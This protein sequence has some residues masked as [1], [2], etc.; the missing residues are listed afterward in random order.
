M[1]GGTRAGGGMAVGG[2]LSWDIRPEHPPGAS[3]WVS[4]QCGSL[5]VLVW[6]LRALDVSVP[7]E[8]EEAVPLF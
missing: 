3:L 6:R 5:S 1:D 4:S 2:D 7:G 8:Q